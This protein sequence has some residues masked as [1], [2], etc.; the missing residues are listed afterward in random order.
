MSQGALAEAE[1]PSYI[2]I[3]TSAGGVEALSQIFKNLAPDLPAAV[4]V[5]LHVGHGREMHWLVERLTRVGRVPVKVAED[6][7]LIR[8]GTAYVAP[9]STHLFTDG[10]HIKLGNG[11]PEQGARPSIDVLFRGLASTFGPRVIGVILTG[12]LRDGSV[13]LRAVHEAG[14]V[15]IVQDPG[16]AA[17]PDMPRNAMRD[18]DVDYCLN[19]SEIAPLLDL[20][21]R[22]AGSHK[23]GVLETGLA[24]SLRLMKDRVQL[25]NK[26]YAQSG[27]NSKTL[28]FLEAELLG[29]NSELASIQEML[30]RKPKL[31]D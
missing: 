11:P 14:G 21:V 17:A 13:G 29:L 26:L 8:Q 25:L 19:L 1:R 10:A 18:L 7:E 31:G 24:T 4:L 9:S 15:S 3:G 6:G 16:D 28:Q 22:R 30:P 27:R 20:L 5:V 12:M 2:V 23:Q